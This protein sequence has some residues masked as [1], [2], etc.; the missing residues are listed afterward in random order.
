MSAEKKLKKKQVNDYEIKL[1]SDLDQITDNTVI[2]D[3][4][5]AV[6]A[7][8]AVKEVPGVI[9]MGG[10][11]F[12]GDIAEKLGKKSLDKGIKVQTTGETVVIDISI[13]VE[14]GVKIPE[15]AVSIQNNVRKQVEEM[16]GKKVVSINLIIQ[17]VKL[18]PNESKE[19]FE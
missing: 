3:D 10:G 18:H 2:N 19:F 11:G 13:F 5:I 12:V 6:I 8:M 1:S 16:A 15:I 7:Y 17:G 4:V 14:Y 9:A